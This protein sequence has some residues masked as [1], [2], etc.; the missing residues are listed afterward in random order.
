[1]LTDA[2]DLTSGTR[3]E[4]DVCVI[5]AGAA[6][7]TLALELDASGLSVLVLESGGT[8]L[9]PATQDLHAGEVVGR[10]LTTLDTSVRLDQTRLR[11]LGGTTNHWAGFCRPLHP[12]DFEERGGLHRSG[13]PIDHGDLVPYWD[14]AASACPRRPCGPSG[15]NR[16]CSR[17]P[18]P[19]CS[20]AST[21][22]SWRPATTWR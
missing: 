2:R 16:S 12:I 20:A 13:W 7:I 18:I 21:A 19:R 14:R 1:M 3:R 5:G 8:D 10:P 11:F 6:G 22:A 4:V 15:S 17:P 9:E